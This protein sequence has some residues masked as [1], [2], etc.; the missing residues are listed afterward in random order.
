MSTYEDWEYRVA[1]MV[2]KKRTAP[3]EHINIVSHDDVRAHGVPKL[4][5]PHNLSLEGQYQW[6]LTMIKND[7]AKI[8]LVD[9][10]YTML[11]DG[12]YTSHSYVGYPVPSILTV[13]ATYGHMILPG[14][15]NLM[16]VAQEFRAGMTHRLKRNALVITASAEHLFTIRG[17]G[18]WSYSR[19]NKLEFFQYGIG[20][21]FQESI[22][23]SIKDIIESPEKRMW[24]A[25]L[26][27]AEGAK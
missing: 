8:T 2:L 26:K 21:H 22:E 1:E 13:N 24:M 5:F 6:I 20:P 25:I 4:R 7:V 19:D 16:I 27:F 23:S 14:Y 15:R 3:T 9:G 17:V 18:V 12:K 11:V 10:K